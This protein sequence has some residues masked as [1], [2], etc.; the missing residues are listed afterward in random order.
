ML[1]MCQPRLGDRRRSGLLREPINDAE[2]VEN[3]GN[4]AGVPWVDGK[5]A[6]P[7][8]LRHQHVL[9]FRHI[10]IKL[11]SSVEIDANAAAMHGHQHGNELALH[12]KQ[13][14]YIALLEFRL[15]L[16]ENPQRQ[17]DVPHGVLA[18]DLRRHAPDMLLVMPLDAEMLLD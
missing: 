6:L 14:P 15:L 11:L 2:L 10:A 18:D 16:L 1:L 4:A 8:D 3:L 12:R 13:A 7:L 5:A 17:V 9:A